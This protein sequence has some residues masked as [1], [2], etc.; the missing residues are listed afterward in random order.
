MIPTDPFVERLRDELHDALDRAS[1]EDK[2]WPVAHNDIR[3]RVRARR[4]RRLSVAAAVAAVAAVAGIILVVQ[5]GAKRTHNPAPPTAQALHVVATSTYKGSTPARLAVGGGALFAAFWDS[6]TVARL[7]PETLQETGSLRVGSRQNGP[8][9]IAY[10]YGSLWV[11]N[12]GDGRLWRVDPASMRPTS[13]IKL[14]AEPS[15]VAV[16]DGAVWVT[17]CCGTT[18]TATRQR[19]LRIDPTSGAIT[20]SVVIPGDGETINLAVG[21]Q[22]L[23]SSQD[24]P[25]SVVDPATL[26]IQRRL[27]TTCDACDGAPGIAVGEGSFYVTESTTVDRFSAN[28]GRVI[29]HSE[30]LGLASTATPLTLAPDGLWVSTQDQLV[31]LDATNLRITERVSLPSTSQVVVA[32]PS[33]LVSTPGRILRLSRQASPSPTPQPQ[34]AGPSAASWAAQMSGKVAY[35]CDNSMCLMNPDATG[36][37]TLGAA[38]PEWDPAWSPD[39]Q[40]LAFRGYRTTQEGS[41]AIYVVQA[42]GCRVTRLPATG[43]GTTPTWSPNGKEIAYAVGGIQIVSVDGTQHRSLT[44]DTHHSFDASPAWSATNRIAFVRT[45]KGSAAGEIYVANVDGSAVAP[46]THGGRGFQQPAWSSDGGS[47]AFVEGRATAIPQ[48]AYV[49][50]VANPDGTGRHA[51]SPRS[52]VSYDPT[53]TPDGHV[54]FLAERGSDVDA[55]M[56]NADGS[57]LRRLYSHLAAMPSSVQISWGVGDLAASRC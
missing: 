2:P 30:P 49:I 50:E 16:G 37:R 5:P 27:H 6:G 8:L 26:T 22:V 3:G 43:G 41:Y 7:D 25:L 52:W 38:L 29:G 53:W 40:Q 42:D 17:V 14:F 15:Q 19:L 24:A 20:G 34:Q 48:G 9:S 21:P 46:L 35:K 36:Q 44:Q 55:Y 39:G 23:V 33:L 10:G 12:F 18:K 1:V 4:Q 11:L 45:P 32:E 13:K 28:T 51:V 57:N 56:V 31:R 47:I 54:V